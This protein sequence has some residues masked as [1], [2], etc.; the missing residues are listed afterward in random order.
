MPTSGIHL[1]VIVPA[2]NEETRLGSTLERITEYLSQQEYTSEIVVVDDGSRD[3][4]S[5][6]AKALSPDILVLRNEPNRGKGYSVKRGMLAARGDFRLFSDADLS[7]PIEEIEKFWRFFDQG[8][9]I[10]IAS[11]ALPGSQVEIHQN[12]FRE[13]SGRAFNKVVKTVAM[14]QFSDTQCGFKAFTANAAETVFAR[15]TI[16]GWVFDTEIL[17]IGRKHKLKMIDVPVI[18]RNSPNSRLNMARDFWKIFMEL[19]SVRWK[20]WMGK[21]K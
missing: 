16:S 3:R 20:N 4:T 1:S 13:M 14:A 6:V 11:R 17:F 12:W 18:W 8:Y 7:T 9:D 19:L 21:Y 10:V 15:Q 2:Y 5:E